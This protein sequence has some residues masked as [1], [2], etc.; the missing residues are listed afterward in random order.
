[1]SCKIKSTFSAYNMHIAE[2]YNTKSVSQV[3]ELC[4][5]PDEYHGY[6]HETLPPFTV[7]VW[8]KTINNKGHL[9]LDWSSSSYLPLLMKATLFLRPK[10]LLDPI[11]PC[12]GEGW[13]KH[14]MW[15]YLPIRHNK[16]K[17]SRNQA[18]WEGPILQRPK[19]FFLPTSPLVG[20][21]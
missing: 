11:T 20:T 14:D 1:M 18:V 13:H 15:H 3:M 10:E 5:L 2:Y 17:I 21:G 7:Q 12:L 16:R 4:R 19:W 6:D 9:M 8:F